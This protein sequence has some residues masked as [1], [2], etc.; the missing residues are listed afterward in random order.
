[1]RAADHSFSTSQTSHVSGQLLIDDRAAQHPVLEL[2][3][4]F[5]CLLRLLRKGRCPYNLVKNSQKPYIPRGSC[6]GNWPDEAAATGRAGGPVLYEE[7]EKYEESLFYKER[8]RRALGFDPPN[9]FGITYYA[10][11]SARSLG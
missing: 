8:S 11:A 7:N 6:P 5:L 4:A 2:M 9:H 10:G 1:M 3:S